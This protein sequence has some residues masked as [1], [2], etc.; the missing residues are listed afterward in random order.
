MSSLY[1]VRRWWHS[2]GHW[3]RRSLKM[4]SSQKVKGQG[5]CDKKA[6][7]SAWLIDWWINSSINQSIHPSI[8][9]SIDGLID[10]LI[11]WFIDRLITT[12]QWGGLCVLGCVG[13]VGDVSA[14]VALPGASIQFGGYQPSAA[15]WEQEVPD[16]GP[17]LAKDHEERKGNPAGTHHLVILMYTLGQI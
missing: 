15:S 5:H 11:D 16:D 3:R 7:R 9:P 12:I 13:R 1:Y 14:S 4:R 8:H 17:S 2:N 10:R 6:E